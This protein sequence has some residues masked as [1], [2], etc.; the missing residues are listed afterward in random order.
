MAWSAGFRLGVALVAL[1]SLAG[2]SAAAPGVDPTTPGPLTRAQAGQLVDAALDDLI[3]VLDARADAPDLHRTAEP[4]IRSDGQCFYDSARYAASERPTEEHWDVLAE[5]AEPTVRKLGMEPSAGWSGPERSTGG[6][7]IARN[8]AN[9]AEFRA[10][11]TAEPRSDP[12][13]Y[14]GIELGFTVPLAEDEC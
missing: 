9:D 3:A 8:P 11:S 5:A 2:C 6:G 13:E 1:G 7:L 4:T 10:R 12:G 14:A